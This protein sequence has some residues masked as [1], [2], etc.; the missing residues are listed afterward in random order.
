MHRTSQTLRGLDF[1][2]KETSLETI[3]AETGLSPLWQDV[4][5]ARLK[6][7]PSIGSIRDLKYDK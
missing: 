3:S 4:F 5:A 7:Y 1:C 6:P 2:G